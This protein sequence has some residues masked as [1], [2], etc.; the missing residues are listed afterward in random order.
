MQKLLDALHSIITA[1]GQANTQQSCKGQA[2][3][4]AGKLA[5]ACG[6]E[7]FPTHAIEVFTAF[8]LECLKE[9]NKFELR[10]TSIS[11]FSDLTVLLK[12]GIAPVFNQV[13]TEV[14]KTCMKEDNFNETYEKKK[15]G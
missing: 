14:L 9:D 3:M 6:K 11:Y 5:S 7:Q 4:C 2:L 8:G 1:Q 13:M 12:E 10:E 15:E